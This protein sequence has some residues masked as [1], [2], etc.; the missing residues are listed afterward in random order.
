VLNIKKET[1][2]QN[3][4]VW[5]T[6]IPIIHLFHGFLFFSTSKEIPN[7][8]I[9]F[10]DRMNF[11]PYPIPG[12]M[13]RN[14]DILFNPE[15]Q[16]FSLKIRQEPLHAR[17]C[18]FGI[19]PPK[20]LVYC[21]FYCRYPGLVLQLDTIDIKQETVELES[22]VCQLSLVDNE[23]YEDRTTVRKS[24][25]KQPYQN[26]VGQRIS[27]GIVLCDPDDGVKKLFF[28]YPDLAVRIIGEYRLQ[29]QL[30]Q[31]SRYCFLTETT[32]FS[33]LYRYKHVSSSFNKNVY[34]VNLAFR[35]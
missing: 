24:D 5:S 14:A 31:L 6:D 18:L 11:L 1:T 28:I 9:V 3:D 21:F 7:K 19:L 22:F 30:M 4:M 32:V 25:E 8:D 13:E 2:N 20:S 26:L 29:C 33:Y 16:K 10:R 23:T 27:T 34:F 12:K 17:S 15:P 35:E